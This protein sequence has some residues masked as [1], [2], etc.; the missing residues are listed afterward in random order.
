MIE[1][2]EITNFFPTPFL[3]NR[4]DES[5]VDKL[6]KAV[7]EEFKRNCKDPETHFKADHIVLDRNVL[8]GFCKNAGVNSYQSNPDLQT[9]EEFAFLNEDIFEAA[10]V[11]EEQTKIIVETFDISL[12]WS[13]IYRP[14]GNNPEHFHP[15]SFISGIII[16]SDPSTESLNGVSS[17]LGGT[18]F[19]SPV[20]QNFIML[21]RV[22]DT[23]SLYYT[24]TVKPELR[25]GTLVLFPSWL[26]HA[27]TPYF[28]NSK[29][30]EEKFR[31]TVSFNI[32]IRGPA[33]KIDL[34]TSHT[35]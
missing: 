30:D 35:Y 15:N 31:I 29:E 1:H 11:Y 34:L 4:L 14:N 6:E 21:P 32:N 17:N 5:T 23:G 8:E 16:V 33:G 3:F 20:N 22:E 9:R 19:Y 13:N 2:S 24:P 25:R 12:M 7:L 26:R 18:T 28:P 10:R 27:A